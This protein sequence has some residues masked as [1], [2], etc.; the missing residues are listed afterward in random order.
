MHQNLLDGEGPCWDHGLAPDPGGGEG[1]AAAGAGLGSH[2]ISGSL[3]VWGCDALRLSYGCRRQR[4][5][6][7]S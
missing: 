4:R 1:R 7:A 3:C 5:S 6:S 2:G